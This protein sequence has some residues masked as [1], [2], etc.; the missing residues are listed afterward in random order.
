MLKSKCIFSVLFL[1][2]IN[3]FFSQNDELNTNS[4]WK[5][6]TKTE[7]TSIA[8]NKTLFVLN[9]VVV[10]EEALK[11]NP[12]NIKTV[13]VLKNEKAIEKYGT[14]GSNGVIEITTKGVSKK[15]LKKLYM[16]YAK[17]YLP[18]SKGKIKIIS[19][20]IVDC[21]NQPIENVEITNLNAKTNSISDSLGNY[22]I[23]ARKNDVLQF[24]KIGFETEKVLI[25]KKNILNISL[26]ATP[27]PEETIYRKPVIYLYP[28]EQLEIEIKLD[29][30]GNLLTTYPK[31]N[32][33]WKVIADPNGQIFDIKTKRNYSSLFWDASIKLP[34]K[35]YQHKDG[36]I[37]SKE[38]L[39]A[40]LIEKLEYIGLNNQET[41]D[42]I[43]FWLPI[44]EQNKYNFIHFLVNNECNEI[45]K[46]NIN[47]KPETTIRVY[48]EYYGLE[49]SSEIKEQILPKTERK[50]F[51]LIEWGG[52]DISKMKDKKYEKLKFEEISK[53]ENTKTIYL[54][55]G[56]VPAVTEKDLA[57]AK[58][59]NIKFHDFGCIAPID[60]KKYEELNMQV[61]EKLNK[62]FGENW[63]KEIKK[64]TLGFE[65]WKKT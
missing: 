62:E 34:Q 28:K 58:K 40:F 22:S 56:I 12:K 63:Q 52:A 30:N 24:T 35:H 15:E 1:L 47:P 36:F 20:K 26:K 32:E 61:F 29:V 18:N 64:E 3:L 8:Q 23:E 7:R 13:N 19:G 54:I 21:E 50:G 4:G 65:K 43:Q 37:I 44:L 5:I 17:T 11:I 16:L 2:T 6:N 9:K 55:G 53:I 45:A 38:K 31:Y 33:K 39:T 49:E 51:T 48:M 25:F 59:Y 41:N 46:L 27:I 42:F 14:R 10:S 57:F 60:F